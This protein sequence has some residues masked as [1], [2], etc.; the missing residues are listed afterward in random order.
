MIKV[1]YDN[2]SGKILGFYPDTVKYKIVPLPFIEITEEQYKKI[3]SDINK[4]KIESGKIKD[5]SLDK[6]YL[7]EKQKRIKT[8][9]TTVIKKII[10]TLELTQH[11]AVREY[12]LT[13]SDKSKRT[14]T[15]IEKK[16]NYLREEIHKK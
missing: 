11:R 6:K 8:Y 13:Q 1:N 7:I 3:M 12:L 14:L 10:R 9:R 4:Y 2:S 15:D 16:I 5:I